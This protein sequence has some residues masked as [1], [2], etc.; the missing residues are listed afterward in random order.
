MSSSSSSAR[1]LD[2][3]TGS[4]TA[5]EGDDHHSPR[6]GE[7]PARVGRYVVLERIGAGGMGVVLSAYDGELDRVVALK[8]L[9]PGSRSLNAG[10]RL[11]REAQALARLSHPHV[12]PIFDVGTDDGRT[13]IA[14]QLVPGRTLGAWLRERRRSAAEVLAMFVQAGRGLAAAHRAGIVHRDFKP[15]NVLI[16]EDGVARVVDFGLALGRGDLE[17]VPQPVAERSLLET[18]L[19]A[20]GLLVGTRAYVA[21]EQ[22]RRLPADARSD[23]YG[24]CVA[25]HEALFGTRPRFDDR[26]PSRRLS[27]AR[28]GSPVRD[29][30]PG[31]VRRALARGLAI[32]PAARFADM[33][34]LIQALVGT[35]ARRGVLAAVVL[36]SVGGVAMQRA[37]AATDEPCA[38]AGDRVRAIWDDDARDRV[39]RAM[40][41]TGVGY[42][43]QSFEL[44]ARE[45]DAHRAAGAAAARQ[46]CLATVAQADAMQAC[47][48]QREA[49]FA[50]VVSVLGDLDARSIERA[51][52]VAFGLPRF[53]DCLDPERAA[54]EPAM[55]ADPTLREQ[56]DALRHELA[57]V[58]ALR[59]ARR[60][61]DGLALAG[62]LQARARATG[63]AP[64]IAEATLA[65]GSVLEMLGEHAAAEQALGD[66]AWL[67]IAH[68]EDRTALAAMTRLVGLVGYHLARVD[69]AAAWSRHAWATTQR[70]S[71]TARELALLHNNLGAVQFRAGAYADAERTYLGV[72]DMLADTRDSGERQE[73]ASAYNN[74][75]NV[76]ARQNRLLESETAIA[77]GVDVLVEL[78]GAGHPTVAAVLIN[79]GSAAYDQGRYA[80]AET[81][82]LRASELLRDS[83]GERHPSYATAL[84]N[85]GPVRFRLGR[86]AE[87]EAALEASI[88]LKR[89]RLGARHP[90]LA[91]SLNNL[92]EVYREHGRVDEAL[93]VHRE[94]L[95]IWRDLDPEHPYASYPRTNVG[96]DLLAQGHVGEAAAAL[97]EVVTGCERRSCDAT[98][99]AAARFGLAQAVL[100]DD[101]PRALA[102]AREAAASYRSIG[103]RYDHELARI[104]V[105]LAAR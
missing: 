29:R 83:V 69:D 2:E 25:L 1:L 100:A 88:E 26:D 45:L 53:D 90:D 20:T 85:L 61:D 9:H 18:P 68:G 57:T 8:L 14:M 10:P 28:T 59:D 97:E 38:R 55:P 7:L 70:V 98:I 105:W 36:A 80:V 51:R 86:L 54:G 103:G 81:Y 32:D 78:L 63:F 42:A 19:T 13:F 84:T 56:V 40:H 31:R 37:G 75:G 101:R 15:E 6:A 11:A 96:L 104:D 12:V 87:A 3:D 23:Q 58:D 94:A 99:V 22:L 89:A 64:L 95:A 21:P 39:E 34:A 27:V 4:L 46:T 102:L 16:G 49:A 66:A 62:D 50:A 41:A 44:V 67:A 47:I 76:Y 73:L 30:V 82:L 92:G 77:R 91:L 72:V 60:F 65:R 48:A 5:T 79:L 43:A 52:S 93:I 35:A 17:C 24:Y 71:P 33:D 74:L